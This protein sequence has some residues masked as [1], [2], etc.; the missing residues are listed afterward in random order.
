M[1]EAWQTDAEAAA[2]EARRRI[3]V[4][5]EAG[6][7][8]TAET[9]DFSDLRA[10]T[11]L[12]AEIAGLARLRR[13]FAGALNAQGKTARPFE[14]Y[15]LTDIAPL[16]GLTGLTT[17]SLARTQVSDIA[18]LAGLTGLTSLDLFH[19]Q[20]SDLAPLSKLTGLTS[21]DLDVTRVS[22][23][24]PLA[25]LT[26]LTSLSLFRTQVSDLAPLA[27]ITGLTS[28]NLHITRVRDLAPL[29]GLTGLTSLDLEGTQVSDLSPLLDIPTFAEE[30][31]KA[32]SF[33][34]TPA[35][36]P[37]RDR[38]LYMLSRLDPQRCA[39]ETV[40]YLK[41]T[42]PDFRGPPGG[43]ATPAQ[44]LA[45][46]SPVEI[47]P[48]DGR[49]EAHNPGPP[50]RVNPEER[51]GRIAGQ[52]AAVRRVLAEA[53][54]S[55]CPRALI[56]RLEDYREGLAGDA[57][58]VFVLDAPMTMIRASLSDRFMTEG[59]D[60]GLHAGFKHLVDGHDRL[61]PL[62]APPPDRQEA[63]I[64]TLPEPGPE[65]TPETLTE[66]AGDVV[67]ALNS[68]EI[69]DQVGQ[70][71]VRTI[72]ATGDLAITAKERLEDRH[73]LL[74]RGFASLGGTLAQLSQAV[75]VYGWLTSPAWAAAMQHIQPILDLIKGLFFGG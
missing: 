20:V 42:H 41:G 47:A 74:K 32:L 75:T 1:A 69:R 71:L 33:Q 22:D 27:G 29:A 18:P 31:A 67:E 8:E 48:G 37:E 63:A 25:G 14:D 28:L 36:D 16:A 56:G 68:E 19:T 26:G 51:D 2:E 44:R 10:L 7:S 30:R 38:R 17:L 46:A 11:A 52:R 59:L 4:A 66:M 62:L 3:A 64:A 58:I 40:R 55:Q 54:E 6:D 60:D 53:R 13:L 21:L 35:A 23:L 5:A 70:E 61:A 12:P 24:V 73:G 72:R 9:L 50:A 39:V 57:P 45:D 15:H 43:G 49:M 65:A 34:D